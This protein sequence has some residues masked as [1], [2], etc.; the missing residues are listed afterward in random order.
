M[1]QI[2]RGRVRAAERGA[3][4]KMRPLLG[5]CR[6]NIGPK[7][8]QAKIGEFFKLEEGEVV[9]FKADLSIMKTSQ[10]TE[11]AILEGRFGS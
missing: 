5:E 3:V 7:L 2:A 1:T 6:I 8:A 11:D 9:E 10:M 4:D